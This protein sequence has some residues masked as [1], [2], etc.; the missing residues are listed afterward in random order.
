MF[1]VAAQLVIEIFCKM[2]LADVSI[3][4]QVTRHIFRI[5]ASRN[6]TYS[7]KVDFTRSCGVSYERRHDYSR[8]N[9]L[10]VLNRVNLLLY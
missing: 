9:V 6:Q 1:S 8:L 3:D 4:L 10:A 5:V 2:N 7:M